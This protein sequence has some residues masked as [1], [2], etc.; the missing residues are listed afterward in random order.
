MSELLKDVGEFRLLSEVVFPSIHQHA[1][2]ADLGNDCAF[3]QIPTTDQTLVVTT[4]AGPRPLVWS[5]GFE[6]YRT[7]GWYTV[8]CNASD[9]AAAAAEPLAFCS[10]VEGSDSMPV[11]DMKEFFA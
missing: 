9:L 6:C 5:L 7:W 2:N 1:C 11:A 4:D 8:V 3:I 10:S